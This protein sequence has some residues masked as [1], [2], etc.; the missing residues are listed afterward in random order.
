MA[1]DFEN[2]FPMLDLYKDEVARQCGEL[3]EALEKLR[4]GD[5]DPKTYDTLLRN[6][7]SLRSAAMIVGIEPVAHVCHEIEVIAEKW[8]KEPTAYQEGCGEVLSAIA[9][10][11]ETSGRLDPQALAN[12]LGES[13][14]QSRSLVDA[15]KTAADQGAPTPKPPVVSE[16]KAPASAEKLADAAEAVE[17]PVSSNVDVSMLD[18]YR[19][20]AEQQ[21]SALSAGLVDWEASGQSNAQ[22]EVLMRAAHSLKGA[23][24]IVGLEPV[25]RLCHVME[26]IM[27]KVQAGEWTLS[28][29]AMD[30]LFATVDFLQR[31]SQSSTQEIGDFAQQESENYRQCMTRLIA[32]RDQKEDQ[33]KSIPRT[34]SPVA[35]EQE[36]PPSP[37][38]A[39]SSTGGGDQV[40]RVSAVHLN[41]LM[42]LAAETLVETRRLDPFRSTLLRVKQSQ[43]ELNSRLSNLLEMLA[44]QDVDVELGQQF[45]HLKQVAQENLNNL[46]QQVDTF[47]SFAQRTS[48]L[49]G[50][51]YRSVLAS[52]MRPF[53]DGVQGFPR[54]VRDLSRSLGKKIRFIIEGKDTPVDRDI[55]ERLEAPL[56]HIIRNACDHGLETPE[57]RLRQGKE[58]T[59]SI[60][61]AAR[62]HSGVLVIEIR[63]DGR[64]IDVERIRTKIL[65]RQLVTPEMAASLSDEEVLDFL[66]LPGFSTADKLTEISGRGVGLD[67]VNSMMQA[68]GGQVRISTRL[69]EGTTFHLQLPVTRSVIR[70][71]LVDIN[72]EPYAFPLSRI[73]RT[74]RLPL[75]SIQCIE[76]RHYFE[77]EG[78]NVGLVSS[79]A[80]LGLAD[81]PVAHREQIDIVVVNDRNHLYGIEVDHLAGETDLVVRPLDARLGKVPG[82]SAAALSEEGHPILILDVEDL[83]ASIDK[84]LAGGKVLQSSRT[85]AG[86]DTV[87]RR[88]VLVV[89]DSLTVRETERQLLENAGYEV[90]VAIDGADGWNAVRLGRFDLVVSDIDMPRMNGFDLV[91]KIKEDSRLKHLPIII[92]SYKDREEDRVRGLEAGAD[93]YLTK[94]SFQDDTFLEAVRDLIGGAFI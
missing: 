10:F 41:R 38:S 90:E 8:K 17:V 80:A 61:L 59:G 33:I 52:R 92:V 6:V 70:A 79:R 14:G 29:E 93:Y 83:V 3:R 21:L 24:R 49:S 65:D 31:L 32:I 57:E 82:I 39:V 48:L 42:G 56:N 22:A 37:P 85:E 86:A 73:T 47:D 26:D 88:R 72:G 2:Q 15:L 44:Q 12:W 55:L 76:G 81:Q 1:D 91:K 16:T 53:S 23:A 66:F 19:A 27:V 67:V 36:T 40:V 68:V 25:V 54:L 63:D 5:R 7:H 51:L 45:E 4:V 43:A 34:A 60:T 35:A 11:L 13:A 71:L 74:L 28:P 77:L 87:L 20:E 9:D 50:R 30:T 18:L 69:G 89:D 62:H 94:S 58:E 46:R 78:S 64:G 75:K 84:L